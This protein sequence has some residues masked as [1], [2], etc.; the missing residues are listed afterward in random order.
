LNYVDNE[1]EIDR[2]IKTEDSIIKLFQSGQYFE[3]PLKKARHFER[4]R[5]VGRAGLGKVLLQEFDNLKDDF[6]LTQTS[7][8]H[9][10]VISKTL[11]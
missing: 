2:L 11:K 9:K 1:E 7:S 6:D 3:L 4:W 8:S 10:S 5:K